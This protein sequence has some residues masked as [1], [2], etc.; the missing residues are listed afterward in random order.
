[1]K[2]TLIY[3]GI[4]Q[5]GFESF[6]RGTPTTDL[7][8]LG[9]GY[10]GASIKKSTKNEVD[11]IDL[12]KLKGWDDVKRE[13]RE[14]SCDIAGI[15]T[16]TVNFEYA[17]KCAEIAHQ[18]GKT[19]IAG[20]PHAT[21]DPQELIDTGNVDH[22]ITG[23]AEITIIDVL[24]RLERGLH[25]DKVIQGQ[26]VENLDDLPFPERD[27]FGLD[28]RLKLPGIFPYPTR[29]VGVLASRGCGF[30][31]KFCQPLERK[32]F[33]KKLKFRSIENV[34]KEVVLLKEHYGADFIMFQDDQLTQNK[35]WLL[36]LCA[37][38]K[39]VGIDWGALARVD[40]VNEQI[41]KTMRE[42][43]CLVLQFG[44]ESGSQRILD[45]LR[46][47]AKVEEAIETA[48]HCR[49]NSMLIFAN[50]MLGIPT[51][52]EADIEDTYRLMRT[53]N[54][55][56]HAASYFSPIPGSDLYEYCKEKGLIN[57]TSYDMYARGAVG[58]KLKGVDYKALGRMK[59]KIEKRTP[60]WY[61]E[62]YYASCVI[63][64]WKGLIKQG[65]YI[66]MLKEF[67]THTPILDKT[68]GGLYRMLKGR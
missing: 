18:M 7:M 37:E 35:G 51:E 42:A 11:L 17:M 8:S 12:R 59:K 6:G 39:K 61:Q 63:K 5:I 50:Y 28:K 68:I 64:R 14:R 23:E 57:V 67:V 53:I 25:V 55:E 44:F 22:I 54:P 19:V 49:E 2:I 38:L 52:T 15:H 32:I 30:N 3:P 56:I 65:H 20:G 10:I 62:S 48:R 34:L 24:K 13:L 27:L 43:G 16:N 47:G 60:A 9:L 46:K 66:H 29:Y 1:V 26:P 40:T 58:N 33:G 21:L 31:C 41:I 36:D 45:F 4:A